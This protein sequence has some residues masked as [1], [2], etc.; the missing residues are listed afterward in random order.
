MSYRVE[1]EMNYSWYWHTKEKK[2]VYTLGE[3]YSLNADRL[4][5]GESCT[6]HIYRDGKEVYT[7]KL[8]KNR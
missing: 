1:T 7:V 5:P 3:A 8:T 6:N 4:E 2:W